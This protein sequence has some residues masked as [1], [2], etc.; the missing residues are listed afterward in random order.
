MW[1]LLSYTGGKKTFD[2]F[3]NVGVIQ[4][5]LGGWKQGML[6]FVLSMRSHF[7][8]VRFPGKNAE[9]HIFWS[10]I[11]LQGLLSRFRIKANLLTNWRP[12]RALRRSHSGYQTSLEWESL[13][14]PVLLT[15][16]HVNHFMGVLILKTKS[17]QTTPKQSLSS[18]YV[19]L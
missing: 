16:T 13:G 2:K 11:Y 7:V 15:S 8:V 3:W 4:L 5:K 1:Q 14:S 9:I 10:Y 12:G 19:I 17:T 18:I 6:G